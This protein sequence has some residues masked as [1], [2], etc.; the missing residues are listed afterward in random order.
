MVQ[1]QRFLY[2]SLVLFSSVVPIWSPPQ[3]GLN[4]SSANIIHR[5]LYK[6]MVGRY[7][8]CMIKIS[9]ESNACRHLTSNKNVK[10]NTSTVAE[11][12]NAEYSNRCLSQLA[13]NE[14]AVD[15]SQM[16]VVAGSKVVN[17]P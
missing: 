12:G 16:S 6:Y 17:T 15:T 10:I 11:V 5:P 4:K 8:Y 9:N 13:E 2:H 7:I 1:K 3:I 14:S